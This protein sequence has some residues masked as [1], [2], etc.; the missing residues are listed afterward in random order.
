MMRAMVGKPAYPG[1]IVI[2]YYENIPS[3]VDEWQK[4]KAGPRA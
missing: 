3:D 2:P 4:F 1:E